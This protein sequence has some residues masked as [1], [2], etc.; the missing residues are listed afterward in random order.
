MKRFVLALL[1]AVA[2][3]LLCLQ[4]ALAAEKPIV[5]GA[6]LRNRISIWMGCGTGH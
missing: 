6:P 2:M 5:I 3:G 1:I 4:P